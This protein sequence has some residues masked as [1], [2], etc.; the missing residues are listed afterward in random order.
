MSDISD[1][2]GKSCAVW[3]W[4]GRREIEVRYQKSTIRSFQVS[5]VVISQMRESNSSEWHP[6]RPVIRRF[7]CAFNASFNI[8][9]ISVIGCS[10]MWE[11][12]QPG[13]G[14]TGLCWFKLTLRDPDGSWKTGGARGNWVVSE[15]L[16]EQKG[17]MGKGEGII[18]RATGGTKSHRTWGRFMKYYILDKII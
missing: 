17:S 14:L 4:C 15:F 5:S 12:R 16:Q 6:E 18:Y 11:P 7:L 8:H 1:G 10:S 2:V 9:D 3:Y 13:K